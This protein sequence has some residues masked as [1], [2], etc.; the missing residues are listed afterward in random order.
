MI[1]LCRAP[2]G[3]VAETLL[4]ARHDLTAKG[5]GIRR[6]IAAGRPPILA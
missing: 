2:G 6:R 5:N 4:Q 1:R 3:V